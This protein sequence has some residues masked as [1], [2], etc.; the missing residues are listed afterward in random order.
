[1]L[2]RKKTLERI[3]DGAVSVAFRR[4]KKPTVKAG[5]RLR[6]AIG[7]L[8]IESVETVALEDI[9]DADIVACGATDRDEL[10]HMLSGDRE[11]EIYRIAFSLAGPDARAALRERATLSD[12]EFATIRR[13]LARKDAASS[14]G[15][16]TER[17]LRMIAAQPDVAAL[18]LAESIGMERAPFKVNVRKLKE[19][20]LTESRRPGY[21]LS[22]CGR[23]YLDRIDAGHGSADTERRRK[24]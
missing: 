15:P 2:I 7:E 18:S 3:A 17:Y 4:W 1:M 23:A 16:W 12:E 6:T 19:L 14:D 5:G 24:T 11:G 8:A 10:A 9:A 21:R 13:S 20:G 22:P